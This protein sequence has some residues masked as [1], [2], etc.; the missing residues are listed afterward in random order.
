MVHKITEELSHSLQTKISVESVDFSFFNNLIL[1]KVYVEDQKKD[2]LLFADGIKV[3]INGF[4]F[5]KKLINLGKTTFM[6]TTFNLKVDSSGR[7]NLQFILDKLKSKKPAKPKPSWSVTCKNFEMTGSRFTLHSAKATPKSYGI[8]FSNLALNDLNIKINNYHKDDG[9]FIFNVKQI[10]FKDRSGFNLLK[11]KGRASINNKKIQIDDLEIK[12][13]E[14]Y[15]LASLYKMSFNGFKDFKNN[16]I[17][18]KVRFNANFDHSRVSFHDISYFARTLKEIH[19]V[20]A[21]NGHVKGSISD[22]KGTGMEFRFGQKTKIEGDFSLYGLP[23]IDETFFYLNFK[24]LITCTSDIEAIDLPTLQPHHIELSP[25]VKKLGTIT[26]KGK[27]SGFYND[28]VAYGNFSS[29]LGKVSSDLWIKPIKRRLFQFSGMIKTTDFDLG[30]LANDPEHIGKVT[31]NIN[32]DGQSKN[33]DIEGKLKGLVSD[34][35]IN[36]YNYKNINIAGNLLHKTFTGSVAVE[37]PYIKLALSGK[38][39]FSSKTPDFNFSADLQRANLHRLNLDRIDTTSNLSFLMNGNFK[40]LDLDDLNGNIEVTNASL[41]RFNQNAKVDR[42]VVS[43]SKI[44]GKNKINLK[45]DLIDGELKGHYHFKTLALSFKKMMT[46]FIPSLNNGQ[47]LAEDSLNN[48]SFSFLL[49]K[50]LPLSQTLLP[51]VFLSDNSSI[52]GEYRPSAHHIL[53]NGSSPMLSVKGTEFDNF[54]IRSTS[55][56]STISVFWNCKSAS[57][58]KKKISLK[59]FSMKTMAVKDD[60]NLDINWDNQDSLKNNGNI[61]AIAHFSRHS[62]WKSPVVNLLIQPSKFYINDSLWYLNKTSVE[63]ENSFIGINNLL[64]HRQ[65]QYIRLDGIISQNEKDT[66]N[67]DISH[68]DL[69]GFAHLLN[70]KGLKTNGIL[71]GSVNLINLYRTPIFVANLR[72]DSLAINNTQIGTT[73]LAALWNNQKNN[74]DIQGISKRGNLKTLDISG[75][76]VPGTKEINLDARLDKIRLSFIQ[77]Y[78]YKTI[79]DINGLLTGEVTLTGN[80]P[81]PLLNG[82]VN[83]QKASFLINYLKTRYNFTNTISISNNNFVVKDLNLYDEN[84]N[85]AVAN[86]TITNRYFADFDFDLNI[87][88]KNFMFFNTTEKDNNTFYGKTFASGI[89]SL[90]G[91]IK[92][93][94]I[95]VTARTDEHSEINIPLSS[96]SDI[97]E[98]RFITFKSKKTDTVSVAPAANQYQVDMTGIKLNFDLDIRPNTQVKLIFDSKIGDII[99]GNGNGNIKLD[100]DTHGKFNMFGEYVIEKGNYL[101]TLGNIINKKFDLESGGTIIW[102]GRPTDATVNLKAVYKLNAS[103][104]ELLVDAGEDYKKRIPIECQLSLN[105]KLMNPALKFDI[106]MPTVSQETRTLVKNAINTDEEMSRQFMSL[107]VVN[108]FLPDPNKVQVNSGTSETS[109]YLTKAGLGVTSFEF[110][111]NQLSHWLS[112]MSKDVDIGLNYRPGDQITSEQMGV[113]LSTQLLNDRI[114]INGNFGVGGNNK[115]ATKTN[116]IAGDFDIDFKLNKNGKLKLKGFNRTNDQF[117]YEVSPYTQGVGITYREEFKSWDDLMNRYWNKILGKK[118]E[119]EP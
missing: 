15:I 78:L 98:N 94:A 108:T 64:A 36:K 30:Q 5:R 1:R 12:T 13:P 119:T 96:S 49:K 68:I 66:L 51:S 107:L 19:S 55:A 75:Y 53:L 67:L 73:N 40:G 24:N 6:N 86:G 84:G 102:N 89:V 106:L 92:N 113:A 116:N 33:K 83:A 52:S 112:Q 59:N 29:D 117:I 77:P 90:E 74:I 71:N 14:T 62:N 44:N 58:N 104:Y 43:A 57:V 81:H 101:F 63:F 34:I 42:I 79:S 35:Q 88:A 11:F 61:Q 10:Q 93:L 20:V 80:F 22:L 16:G 46:K 111:T 76:Y 103:L 85:K 3:R 39:N 31:M 4:H 38:F 95:N 110:L 105:D 50:T 109:S 27:F 99:W 2:T 9:T 7:T 72:I 65:N 28:F 41:H 114:S 87:N 56:D 23:V 60:V 118:K 25:E 32:V 18:T 70:I 48:F 47:K 21:L 45:S 115:L 37:D 69:S 97:T 26:Y 8:D 100:I 54:N 91:N 82:D 17:L